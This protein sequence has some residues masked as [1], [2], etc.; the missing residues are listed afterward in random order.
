MARSSPSADAAKV[1]EGNGKFIS[2]IH[3]LRC[4]H[5]GVCAVACPAN[6]IIIADEVEENLSEVLAA[7]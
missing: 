2:F 1:Q 3:E 4:K 5:C 7:I 6:A